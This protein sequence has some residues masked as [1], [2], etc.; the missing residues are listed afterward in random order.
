MNQ[1]NNLYEYK[2]FIFIALFFGILFIFLTPPINSPDEDSHFKKAYQVSTFNFFPIVKD[3]KYG[4]YFPKE[5]LKYIYKMQS[6]IDKRDKKV[7]Y[8]D[9]LLDQNQPMNYKNKIFNNYSTAT[10]N[11]LV[12][13]PAAIG[14][15][16]SKICAK[17]IGLEGNSV[18]YMIY[19]A[20]LFNLL[21]IIFLISISIKITPI[22]KKTFAVAGVLPMLLFLCST[23]TYDGIINALV[24]LFLAIIFD[25]SYNK[26]IKEIPR[27]YI[28]VL[29][30]IGS[31]LLTVKTV[32][33]LIFLLMFAIPIDKFSG[34]KG[35]IKMAFIIAGGILLIA[36]LLR[37]PFILNTIK[38]SPSLTGK[39]ISCIINNPFR[40]LG[41]IFTNIVNSRFF[42]INGMIG[43]FGLIDTYL[44]VPV[45][46]FTIINL[47]FVGIV[48]GNSEKYKLNKYFKIF[49]IVYIVFVILLIYI[50]M[51]I[52]WTVEIGSIVCGKVISG[53]QG[54][55]F[56]PLIIPFIFLF[57]TKKIINKNSLLLSIINYCFVIPVMSLIISSITL[58]LRFW[59]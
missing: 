39:Q 41:L 7:K 45:I 13:F 3:N 25:I 19:F 42:L 56:I 5:M 38:S 1:V 59:V 57:S 16:F 34:I 35:K 17:I 29:I 26:R 36:I 18:A 47:F 27:K 6:F 50:V 28:I 55:Y 8:S 58:L 49:S 32:Y 15:L 44:P 52:S 31:V 10:V 53:I 4:N 12:Y 48:E 11:F 21:F 2:K 14:I 33:S 46:I 20:R 30:L 40:F 24:L 54:R 23:V 37:I 43:L 9:I 22:Y 51:Y